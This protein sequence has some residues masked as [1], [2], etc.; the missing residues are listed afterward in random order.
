VLPLI[1]LAIVFTAWWALSALNQVRSGA[2]TA[3]VRRYL[4]LAPVP[5]W[6]FFAPNPA[7]ADSRLVWREEVDGGWNDWQELHFGF[8]PLRR[9][10]LFNPELI[11]NKAVSDL[12]GALLSLPGELG[13]RGFILSSSYQAVLSIVQCLSQPDATGIQFAVVRTAVGQE[14]RSL[15]VAFVSE[16][17]DVC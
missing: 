13:Q 11:E 8:A 12:T 16:V 15:D 3:R 7:R 6:T 17:H 5:W 2:W 14:R 4:P 9:R 1:A 10:W